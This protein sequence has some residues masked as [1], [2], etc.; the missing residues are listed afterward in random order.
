M[1]AKRAKNPIDEPKQ[2]GVLF[3]IIGVAA[4]WLAMFFEIYSIDPQSNSIIDL[5]AWILKFGLLLVIL[6]FVIYIVVY[7]F[8]KRRVFGLKNSPKIAKYTKK[9]YKIINWS[10]LICMIAAL[11][12]FLL[13]DIMPWILIIITASIIMITIIVAVS[14]MIKLSQKFKK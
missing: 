2:V 8:K 13:G 1:V 7:G 4:F 3:T 12:L 11:V 9:Y 10:I 6:G 5:T 14:L